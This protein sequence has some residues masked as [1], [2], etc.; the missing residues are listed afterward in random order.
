MSDVVPAAP[1]D[2]MRHT[3]DSLIGMWMENFAQN[4]TAVRSGKDLQ[5]LPKKPEAC[6]CIGGGPSLKKFNHLKKIKDSGWK[7]PI[8]TCDKEL[9]NCLE[10]GLKPYLVATVDASPI[11]RKFYKH[12]LVKKATDIN[13]AFNVTVHPLV[14]NSFRGPVYWYVAM[15]DPVQDAAGKLNRRSPTYILYLLSG[16]KAVISGIGNVGSF[17]WNVATDLQCSP[18]ILV[19]YDFS[20]QVKD[21]AQAVYFPAFTAMYMQKYP[22]NP[23]K[24]QNLAADLHQVE[25]NKDFIAPFT[26]LP[27]MKKGEH[28]HYLVNPMW[29]RYRESL[30]MHIVASKKHTINASGN[31]CLTTEAIK[32]ENFEA[33]NLEAVLEKY[34]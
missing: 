11:I 9:V 3:Y 31:G 4:I 13:A 10:M 26:D 22:N 32:C 28:P 14:R 19:G 34:G 18:I 15:M 6:I 27:Y 29:K 25:V 20:E 8:L 24:A 5:N 16:R 23:E 30:A 21:K 33:S 2:V 17:L 7:H 1:D 12:K